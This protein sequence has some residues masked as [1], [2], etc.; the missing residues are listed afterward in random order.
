M[1]AKLITPKS[2]LAAEVESFAFA[3]E[4]ALNSSQD[5]RVEE[6]LPPGGHEHYKYIVVELLRID[7]EFQW[8]RKSP[9]SLDDYRRR[10]PGVLQQAEF[11]EPL[12]FE[13]WRQRTEG[14][15]SVDRR[16]YEICYG[17]DASR[18]PP[19]GGGKAKAKVHSNL[20]RDDQTEPRPTVGDF[21][22]DFELV[23]ELGRGSFAQV[24]LARQLSLSSRLVALKISRGSSVEPDRL[25]QLQHANIVPIYSVYAERGLEAVCM[26]FLGRHTLA[27]VLDETRQSGRLPRSGQ[28][29]L[30]TLAAR[31]GSTLGPSPKGSGGSSSTHRPPVNPLAPSIRDRLGRSSYIDSA[32]WIIARL[33]SGLAHAHERGVLHRDL[34]PANVLF[35]S[36]GRPMILDFN[37]SDRIRST[38]DRPTAVG[39]TLP[40][41]SPE[42]L[43]ALDT[44]DSVDERSD[45]FSLGVIFYEL[46]TGELPFKMAAPMSIDPAALAGERRLDVA[47]MRAQNRAIPRSLINVVTRCLAHDPVERYS[48]AEHLSEDVDAHL[49]DRPLLHAA[50]KSPRERLTKWARRHPRVSSAASIAAVASIVLIASLLAWAGRERQLRR[51]HAKDVF[52]Q[53]AQ[54]SAE[55]RIP[56]SLIEGDAE[57]YR[58]GM[59]AASKQLRRYGILDNARWQDQS[60]YCELAPAEKRTLK[61]EASKTLFAMAAS[62]L[63]QVNAAASAVERKK[64]LSA[65]R[66]F[67][68]AAARL[69]DGSAPEIR[70]MIER[71][72][73]AIPHPGDGKPTHLFTKMDAALACADAELAAIRLMQDGRF[74]A[75]LPHL[76]RWRDKEPSELTAWMFLGSAYAGVGKPEEAES[77]FTACIHLRSTFAASYFQRGLARLQQKKYASAV[78]DFTRFAQMKGSHAAALVNRALAYQALGDHDLA[79]TDLDAALTVSPAQTRIY[80]IRAASRRAMGN[81]EGAKSDF[82]NGLSRTPGDAKSWI[83]RG[84]A[85]LP[86]SPQMAL[87][88][89]KQALK[90]QPD[91]RTA[92]QNAIHVLSDRLGREEDALRLVNDVIA[93]NPQ[94]A[95][96]LLSRAV[97]RARLGHEKASAADAKAALDIDNGPLASLQ[98]ACALARAST[99]RP[100]YRAEALSLIARALGAQPELAAM[101]QIDPDL[102]AI[103][104]SDEFAR[105]LEAT[106]TIRDGGKRAN[107][108]AVASR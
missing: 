58:D 106:Q 74:E 96:A 90:A 49:E 97:I 76:Q 46:L 34:K 51:L 101:A 47:R 7:I 2:D 33:A 13:E 88:D 17:I 5:V 52:R 79:V 108:E 21:F 71:Q 65:A 1:N 86:R 25:A 72:A 27:D 39:G 67:N 35:S 44:G 64:L 66:S 40:Y 69:A 41:M 24:F 23:E 68:A 73:L 75:A 56:L 91:N 83:A 92:A 3:Y 102:E 32:A 19:A 77:C 48:S 99:M 4:K 93:R 37:L 14:G 78:N 98:A 94:D 12:A 38:G 20:G 95:R 84:M 70:E 59:A 11:L 16:Q 36:D 80:F 63:G 89:F 103:R 15:E 6:F 18:W 62:S 29:F 100:E 30:S 87:A 45:I 10:F 105:I 82:R 81:I 54:H 42:Q 107:Q 61:R 50:D 53:F 28:E 26:P 57:A 9:T 104:N 60:L 31:L 22:G 43:M 8:Q 55:A 85:R